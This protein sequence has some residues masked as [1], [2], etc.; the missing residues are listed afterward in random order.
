MQGISGLISQNLRSQ[1]GYG[2]KKS[3]KVRRVYPSGGI[4]NR[5]RS[6]RRERVQFLLSF[7]S[8]EC[9]GHIVGHPVLDRS[10]QIFFGFF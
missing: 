6:S 2:H 8:T 4:D 7:G 1:K 9:P 5:A 3:R 10:D